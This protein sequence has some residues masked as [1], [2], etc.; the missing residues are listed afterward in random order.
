M[1]GAPL[2]PE[3]RRDPRRLFGLFLGVFAIANALPL[4]CVKHLPFTDLPE[5]VAAMATIARLLP[6]GGQAP[7][8]LELGKSQYLLYHL[9]GALLTRVVGDAVLANQ[10]VLTLVAVAWPLAMRRLLRALGRDERIALF[11]P[12]VF[13]NRAL[14]VGFLPFIA[15]LPL[16]L[17]ALA[18][19][20][21]HCRAP[22][23]RRAVGLVGLSVAL[24]YV[25]ASAYLVFVLCAGAV[26]TASCW[27]HR[28]ALDARRPTWRPLLSTLPL[29]LPS[30]LAAALWWSTGSLAL[31]AGHDAEV[32]R[33]S[34]V[35]TVSALPMWTFDIWKSHL[36]EVAAALWWSAFSLIVVGGLSRPP[37]PGGRWVLAVLPFAVSLIV[38][39]ATPHHVGAAGYLNVRLAPLVTLLA[40]ATLRPREDLWGTVPLG[41]A[42]LATMVMA[43]SSAGEI[44]RVSEERLGDFDALLAKAKPGGRLAMLDF[45]VASPRTHEWPYVFAGSL[46]RARGGA[47][48]A[49]SFTDLPHWPV[50][51]APGLGPPPSMPFW[52][53][54][55]CA[56][57][58]R[59]DGTYY[60]YVLVQG[61]MN[62]WDDEHPRVGPTFAPVATSGAFTLYAKVS[63]EDAAPDA[64]EHGPCMDGAVDGS[65]SA[66]GIDAPP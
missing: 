34:V 61:E 9:L 59:I 15:A 64:P 63:Q 66:D 14:A 27:V 48:A 25:H 47:V 8:V 38:Y 53:Y 50:H 20:L 32:V 65:P 36:D 41:M 42:A 3:R 57:R 52:V 51:Y 46:Y 62:P 33:M 11:A 55:P 49:Y 31:G 23:R 28:A 2:A 30:A 10:L 24:F 54:R 56:Y 6:G 43:W 29:L 21:D 58:Y 19:L 7:Y 18:M 16:A 45:Q 5:H 22:T 17:F 26:A 35:D 44:Q 13:W 12:M 4:F 60:D 39:V 40:L 37:E 1:E